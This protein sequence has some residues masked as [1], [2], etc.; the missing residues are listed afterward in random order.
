MPLI[1]MAAAPNAIEQMR[2]LYGVGDNGSLGAQLPPEL[3]DDGA[4]PLDQSPLPEAQQPVVINIARPLSG[5]SEGVP[6]PTTV[7]AP[8]PVQGQSGSKKNLVV[9]GLLAVSLIGILSAVRQK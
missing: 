7:V 3:K 5:L 4:P 2:T 9:G 1:D 6:P 8:A